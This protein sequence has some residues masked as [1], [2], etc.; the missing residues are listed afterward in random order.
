MLE[1]NRSDDDT[2]LS[3]DDTGLSDDS[4]EDDIPTSAERKSF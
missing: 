1:D 4:L 3:D 2:G